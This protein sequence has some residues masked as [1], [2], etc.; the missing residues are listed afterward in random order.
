[1]SHFPRRLQD[2]V[3]TCLQG[4]FQRGFQDKC[5][6]GFSIMLSLLTR[7]VNETFAKKLQVF[8]TVVFTIE[9]IG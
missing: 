6:Q 2:V 5:L 8:E 1:M 3:K 9:K 4:I 7:E